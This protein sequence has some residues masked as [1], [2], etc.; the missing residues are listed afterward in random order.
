MFVVARFF[1]HG[2]RLPAD[3]SIY[4]YTV[5]T[6]I[7]FILYYYIGIRTSRWG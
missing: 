6:I 3:T 1:D 7:L 5:Y 2:R 4:T